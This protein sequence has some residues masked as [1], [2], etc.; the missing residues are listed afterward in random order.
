MGIEFSTLVFIHFFLGLH[1]LG[2]EHACF[3]VLVVITI[4]SISYG[5][6]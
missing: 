4:L 6:T 3:N 5:A 2:E 1:I